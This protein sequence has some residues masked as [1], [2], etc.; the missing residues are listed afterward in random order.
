MKNDLKIT[1]VGS[2]SYLDWAKN[3]YLACRRMGIASDIIY[4]NAFPAAVGGNSDSLVSFFERA[5]L[6]VQKRAP[7][8]FPFLKKAR[9]FLSDVELC[10]KIL[11]GRRAAKHICVYI[12]IPGSAWVLRFLKKRN[13]ILV[14]WLGESTARDASWEPL[15]DYFHSVFMV[16]NGIWI[17]TIHEERNRERVQLLPLAADENT[18][19]P[20]AGQ[21]KDIDVSFIGKYLPSRADVLALLKSYNLKI[22]GYGWERGFD[23]HP[24]LKDAYCGA[25]PASEL[26]TIYNQS[27]IAIGT[28]WLL[29]ERY[30]G[31]TTRIFEVALAGTFQIAE[32]FP[33]SRQLFG[34]SIEYFDTAEELKSK[35]GYY[36]QHDAERE[37]RA[38]RAREEGLKYTY[39]E[40]VKK[41][42]ASCGVI[43]E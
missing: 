21:E 37:M 9:R 3:F 8:L 15:F 12:W 10:V 17:D 2:A 6:L 14:L 1:V 13:I 23:S 5:K 18:F 27:K 7:F 39:T 41:I 28:L 16:Y 32:D 25:A 33:L 30:T 42:T 26:N 35:V 40:A 38:R 43:L 20:I 11:V 4:I 29:K 19:F 31:P 22:Y 24:W 34:D 36:L